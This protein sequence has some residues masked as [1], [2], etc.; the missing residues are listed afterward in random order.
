MLDPLVLLSHLAAVVIRVRLGTRVTIL[1]YRSP[2]VVAKHVQD[3]WAQNNRQGEAVDEKRE[4][5][6]MTMQ[7]SG[8]AAVPPVRS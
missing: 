6:G 3:L 1:P 2:I 8:A 4:Q 5:L 7:V